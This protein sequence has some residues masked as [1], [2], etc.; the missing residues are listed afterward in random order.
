MEQYANAIGLGLSIFSLILSGIFWWNARQQ[1]ASAERTLDEIKSQVIGWQNE[2][3]RTALD[4][5]SARPE[6][7]AQKTALSASEA[8]A[9]FTASLAT[10]VQH[11]AHT[12]SKANLDAIG[13]LLK[14]QEDVVLGKQRIGMEAAMRGSR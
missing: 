3:N 6:M 2:L 9:K 14:H 12:D 7:I 1:T 13:T 4:L 5:L 8:E 11:L 10:I